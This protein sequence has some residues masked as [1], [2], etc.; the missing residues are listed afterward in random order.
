MPRSQ[1]VAVIVVPVS[2]WLEVRI[3]VVVRPVLPAVKHAATALLTPSVANASV[4]ESI[5]DFRVIIYFP[6]PLQDF[7]DPVHLRFSPS[8]RRSLGKPHPAAL[9]RAHHY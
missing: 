1:P 6:L 9:H 2:C 5:V 7:I 8:M 4:I 3:I